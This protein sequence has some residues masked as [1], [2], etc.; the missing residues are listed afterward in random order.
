MSDDD[1]PVISNLRW[2]NMVLSPSLNMLWLTIFLSKGYYCV[3]LDYSFKWWP[4]KSERAEPLYS[5][6]NAFSKTTLFF[7][8]LHSSAFF[9]TYGSEQ[10][11]IIKNVWEA[12]YIEIRTITS[13][14]VWR[15]QGAVPI[16]TYPQTMNSWFSMLPKGINHRHK[17]LVCYDLAMVNPEKGTVRQL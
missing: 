1:D 17:N 10:L 5:L 7:L 15:I 12:Q 6:L 9:C 14:N 11:Y 13:L 4:L 16:R 8:L 3:I 2:R